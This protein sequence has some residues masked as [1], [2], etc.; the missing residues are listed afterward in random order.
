MTHK[1]QTLTSLFTAPAKAYLGG[2]AGIGGITIGRNAYASH[3]LNQE[4]D[5]SLLWTG[6]IQSLRG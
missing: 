1:K 6:Q 5:P 3:I 4:S 2:G